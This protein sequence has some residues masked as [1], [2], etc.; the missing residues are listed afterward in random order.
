MS[1]IAAFPPPPIADD[2]SALPSPTRPHPPVNNSFACSLDA[3]PCMSAGMV[4]DYWTFQR[5]VL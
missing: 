1:E 4:L 2:P 3:S 5:T